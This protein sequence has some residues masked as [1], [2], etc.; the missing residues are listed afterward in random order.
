MFLKLN[1]KKKIR[2]KSLAEGYR[3]G[4][5]EDLSI[6]KEFEQIEDEL[7]GNCDTR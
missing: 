1:S 2:N 5:N 6:A 3:K 7:D 4:A